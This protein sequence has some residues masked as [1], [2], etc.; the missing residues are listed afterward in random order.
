[1]STASFPSP[2]EVVRGTSI[3][4]LA[5]L[6]SRDFHA[7]YDFDHNVSV[8]PCP[9]CGLVSAVVKSPFTWDC[10]Q[11]EARGT[12]Y[13]LESMV[14]GNAA[15][16]ERLLSSYPGLWPALIDGDLQ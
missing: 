13:L 9:N 11:C 12:R 4:T 15:A 8:F 2:Q 6:V 5:D 7:H 10:G 1:M 16:L 3:L 14:L